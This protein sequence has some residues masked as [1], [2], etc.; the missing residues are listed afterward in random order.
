MWLKI[1]NSRT[2]LVTVPNFERD[3]KSVQLYGRRQT[4]GNDAFPFSLSYINLI[5]SYT[6]NILHFFVITKTSEKYF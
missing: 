2:N 3:E 1:G 4:D 5:Y 6:I